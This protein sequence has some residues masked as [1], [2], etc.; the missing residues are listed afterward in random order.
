MQL[1]QAWGIDKDE[2]EGSVNR[3][4]KELQLLNVLCRKKDGGLWL[5]Y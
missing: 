5:A 4:G 3:I 1:V 2:I